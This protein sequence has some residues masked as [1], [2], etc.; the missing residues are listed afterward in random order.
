M[1][2]KKIIIITRTNA[3]LD[4]MGRTK[5]GRDDY[6]SAIQKELDSKTFSQGRTEV[7]KFMLAMESLK[8]WKEKKDRKG[9][10]YTALSNYL[11]DVLG[12]IKI[13][14]AES[15]KCL[16]SF[17]E[18]KF[19]TKE[20]DDKWMK[21]IAL[22]ELGEN[23]LKTIF[24]D[25]VIKKN[26]VTVQDVPCYVRLEEKVDG[27]EVILL[28]W[29]KLDSNPDKIIE[30]F[31]LFVEKLCED[32]EVEPNEPNTLYIHDK[33]L[34][35]RWEDLTIVNKRDSRFISKCVNQPYYETLA[36]Y[37]DYVAAFGH[38]PD[39]GTI[40]Q[41]L[42]NFEFGPTVVDEITAIESEAQSFQLVREQTDQ[43]WNTRWQ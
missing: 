34:L 2:N 42:L 6:G 8:G 17:F 26:K 38:N 4:N 15:P 21:P 32:C 22:Y 9:K 14:P 28:L 40:F 27:Y 41:G 31:E 19:Q 30:P 13:S 3:Y 29:D 39:T 16:S 43:I 12:I 20:T 36:Y 24:I 25:Q 10:P 7:R 11:K 1:S 5:K 35:G 33:Q 18:K 23:A 37:F